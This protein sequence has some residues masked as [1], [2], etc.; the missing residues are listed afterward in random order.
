MHGIVTHT[1]KQQRENSRN[2]TLR[3]RYAHGQDA[4]TWKRALIPANLFSDVKTK[5][6]EFADFFGKLSLS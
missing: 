1:W 5:I 2:L 6:V 4:H 3:I